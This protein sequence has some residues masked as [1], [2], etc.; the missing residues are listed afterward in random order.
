MK[1]VYL[2][3]HGESHGN[4]GSFRQGSEIGLTED[5]EKQALFV[6]KRFRDVKIDKVFSSPQA[7]AKITAETI[8]KELNKALIETNYPPEVKISITDVRSSTC[9]IGIESNKFGVGKI[10]CIYFLNNF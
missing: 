7:R 8:A 3:R 10:I 1:K 2:V 4:V 6:A 5:G 9:D